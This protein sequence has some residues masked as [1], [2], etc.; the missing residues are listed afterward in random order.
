MRKLDHTEV[1]Q[2]LTKPRYLREVAEHFNISEMHATHHLKEALR[3]GHVLVSE[4]PVRGSFPSFGGRFEQFRGFLYV[5]S[6]SP[7]LAKGTLQL[8]SEEGENSVSAAT[9]RVPT[10][11]I[12]WSRSPEEKDL[13]RQD[14]SAFSDR[15]TDKMPAVGRRPKTRTDLVSKFLNVLVVKGKSVRRTVL[16]EHV[17]VRSPG[18]G[19]YESLSQV[20]RIHLFEAISDQPLTFLELH[21]RFGVSRQVVQG[22]VRRGLFEE[23]WGKRDIGVTFR[24]TKKG[25]RYLKELQAA[26]DFQ[27]PKNKKFIG[28]KRRISL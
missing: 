17:Q 8:S 19:T 14:I 7:L 12:S 26:A 1:L 3:L 11:F 6:S 22:L 27:P 9:G 2:F 25:Q 28:L 21:S 18:Q 10:K 24:L 13:L 23:V 5:S 20:E 4:K 16:R 15:K